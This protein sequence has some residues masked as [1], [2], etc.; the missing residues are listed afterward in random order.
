MVLARIDREE[1]Y[2]TAIAAELLQRYG[3]TV[4]IDLALQEE[5]DTEWSWGNYPFPWCSR[6]EVRE[7]SAA[8]QRIHDD[9][10]DGRLH[11]HLHADDGHNTIAVGSYTTGVRRHVHLH[12]ENHL[13]QVVTRFDDEAEAIAEFQR[14][15]SVAV[16]PGPA[17][18]TD[19]ER[20]VRQA[21]LGQPPANDSAK[22]SAT[23][24]AVPPVA[25]LG[26]HEKFLVSFLEGNTQWEKY[27]TWS[28]ETTIASHESLTVQAEFDHEA[29]HRT[30]TA[31]T[32]AQYNGPVGERLWHATLTA[33]TP[34]PLVRTLLQHVDA[35]LPMGA[36][37]PHE[38]LRDAGWHPSSHPA[39]TT[40]RAPNRTIALDHVPHSSDDRWTLYGGE[41]LDRA[42]WII[43]LSAGVGH[44]VLAQ[45][46]GTA[47]ELAE[48][49]PVPARR[50][51][52]VSQL[53]AAASQH[54]GRVR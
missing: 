52:L 18:L 4:D 36:A 17:P 40:W 31:W 20:S 30:D 41:D 32:V 47:A 15:Y 48:P 50:T 53:P 25:A 1:P 28:D 5:I 21:L 34:V 16:R 3:F 7:V 9:I 45:L 33:A 10:A 26:E 54:R 46:A 13:R 29:R 2:Y 43:R 19:L 27:R 6:Q 38:P 12:G 51:P 42:A 49:P 11:I 22:S 39:W 14:L 8:A 35:P 37:E 24:P 23:A 44:D